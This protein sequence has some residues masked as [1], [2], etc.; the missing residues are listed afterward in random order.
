MNYDHIGELLKENNLEIEKERELVRSIKKRFG[1]YTHLRFSKSKAKSIYRYIHEN[2]INFKTSVGYEFLEEVTRHLSRSDMKAIS[3][4]VIYSKSRDKAMRNNRPLLIVFTTLFLL[5]CLI[6]FGVYLYQDYKTWSSA[7]ALAKMME[8]STA[9]ETVNVSVPDMAFEETVQDDPVASEDPE[10]AEPVMQDKFV[11]LYEENPD[12]SGWLTIEG[13]NI[14]YPVM[15]RDGD[16]NY[17]LK[18]NFYGEYDRNGLLILDYRCDQTAEG[19]NMIIYGHNM[20]TGV[21]FGTLKRYKDPKFAEKHPTF[22]YQGLY[23]DME[24]EVVAVML[25][26]VA[27]QDEDVFRYYDTIEMP[28]MDDYLSFFNYVSDNAIFVRDVEH[29]FGDTFLMLSTCD[30]TE[31]DGRLVVICKKLGE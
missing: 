7:R 14:D 15:T 16:N 13:T 2:G 30:Y 31:K 25:S 9:T 10:T 27:Y 21:M 17:Y 29:A 4:K 18:S 22:V 20:K 5:T 26:R 12:I 28:T 1:C 19:Q 11:K 6:Y 3:K 23:E 24:F 8:E